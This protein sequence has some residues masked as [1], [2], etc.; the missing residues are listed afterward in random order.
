MLMHFF[1]CTYPVATAY[2][3]IAVFDN[4]VSDVAADLS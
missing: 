3:R 4:A 1:K 2:V